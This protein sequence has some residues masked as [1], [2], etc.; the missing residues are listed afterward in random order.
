MIGR[1]L[2]ALGAMGFA[3]C[4]PSAVTQNVVLLNGELNVAAPPDYCADLQSSRPDAGFAVFA[5]CATLLADAP[6]PRALGVVTVQAGPPASAIVAAAPQALRD[7]LASPQGAGLLAQGGDTGD[8]RVISARADAGRVIVHLRDDGPPPM[9]G[10]GAEEW[11]GFADVGTR[12]VTV[13]VRGLRDAP[14]TAD[15]GRALLGQAMAGL[16]P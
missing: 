4:A 15:S 5:P 13:W 12:L 8:L 11:R 1:V 2:I 6:M 10:L 7:F 16:A 9:A 3:A 14:L